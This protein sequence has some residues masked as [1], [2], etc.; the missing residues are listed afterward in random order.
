[1][2]SVAVIIPIPAICVLIEYFLFIVLHFGDLYRICITLYAYSPSHLM[3]H[4]IDST[5]KGK[6]STLPAYPKNGM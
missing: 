3:M 6:P 4:C 1:M 2:Q 5:K